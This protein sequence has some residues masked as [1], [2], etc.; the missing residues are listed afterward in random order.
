MEQNYPNPFN[1]ITS[2]KFEVPESINSKNRFITL[3]IY[4]LLGKEVKILFAAEIN[5]GIHVVNWDGTNQN[6]NTVSSG[7]YL[8]V[9]T[10]GEKRKSLKIILNK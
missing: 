5:A 1:S 9:L 6:G 3:I 4:D 2:I 8:L 7:Q 10:D